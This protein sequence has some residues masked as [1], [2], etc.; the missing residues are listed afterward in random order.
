MLYIKCL[1]FALFLICFRCFPCQYVHRSLSLII[2]TVGTSPVVQLVEIRLSP[3][4]GTG[5]MPGQES[6]I[7]CMLCSVAK[8][9]RITV[10][11]PTIY[12]TIY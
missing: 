3:A 6:K 7:P 11:Y 4:G 12:I 1:Q 5:S 2:M 10:E 9:I 8:I